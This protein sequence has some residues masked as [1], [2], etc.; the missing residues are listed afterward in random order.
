[1]FR[2]RRLTTVHRTRM[3]ERNYHCRFRPINLEP[4]KP[5]NIEKDTFIPRQ[6]EVKI[7]WNRPKKGSTDEL[8]MGLIFGGVFCATVAYHVFKEIIDR[9]KHEKI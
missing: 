7:R 2:G 4:P 8:F 6:E 3:I 9:K 5:V 1:M